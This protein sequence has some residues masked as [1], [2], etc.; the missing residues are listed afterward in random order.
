MVREIKRT[1]RQS[2]VTPSSTA[3]R[4]GVVDVYSPN[5]SQ[6]F[7]AV[8]DTINTLAENQ[9]KVLDAKWQNNFET[10]TTKYLNNKLDGIL[11]S[12]EKP[13]LEKFQEEADGYINGV[14]TG[15]PE[16]LSINAESYYNQKNISAFE[17]LRKQ[18]NII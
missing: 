8:S 13:D 3:A 4:M 14:L 6:M 16:R 10:E 15:V 5:V 1:R 18:A 12:G 17:T 2:M 9:V 11:K 7:G